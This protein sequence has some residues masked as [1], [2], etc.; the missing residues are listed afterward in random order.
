VIERAREL[1]ERAREALGAASMRLWE[2]QLRASDWSQARTLDRAGELVAGWLEGTVPV[3][4]TYCGDPDPETGLLAGPL[5]AANR[6]GYVT[7]CSQAAE[8]HEGQ[9]WCAW[10]WG[11]VADGVRAR[12]LVAMA[13]A[14]GLFAH[15]ALPGW[16]H[17]RVD[18][19]VEGGGE[20]V[21]EVYV[22]SRRDAAFVFDGAHRDLQD[23]AERAW[24]V[25]L[26]DPEPGRNDRLRAVLARFAEEARRG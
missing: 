5:A 15:A 18:V 17:R 8:W 14:E 1:L 9:T 21:E 24:Q 10:A 12:D 13:E 20:V 26:V 7:H 6:A 19:P 22:P 4:P 23:A 25:A 11:M 3:S 16:R 2:R